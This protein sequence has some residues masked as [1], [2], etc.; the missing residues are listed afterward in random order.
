M[1][2][3]A[4]PTS[5]ASDDDDALKPTHSPT[6]MPTKNPTR[7]KKANPLMMDDDAAFDFGK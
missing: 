2:P 1:H 5:L 6:A 7:K 4:P 3:V